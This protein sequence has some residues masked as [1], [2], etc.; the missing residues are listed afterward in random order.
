MLV[1]L[2][3]VV[4][5]LQDRPW[6]PSC[7]IIVFALIT[8]VTSCVGHQGW[9]VPT[10]TDRPVVQKQSGYIRTNDNVQIYYERAG[11]GKNIILIPGSG[12]SI[13][14][15]RRNFDALA[16]QFHVVAVDMRGSGRSQKCDWGHNCA[17][18][19]MD[20][21]ELLH[22]LKMDNVTLVGWSCG[23]RTSYSYLMLFGNHRLHGVVVV[24][25][26]V[27]HT[28][29]N[30]NPEEARQNP[31]ESDEKFI[32]RSMRRMVSP[33]DPDALSTQEVD[34]MV[35]SWT[36]PPA[37]LSADGKAQDWR[38]LCPVIDVPVLI[39]SGR[40]SGALPGCRYAAEHIPDARLEIFEHSGHGLFYSEAEKFNQ[41]VADFVDGSLNSPDNGQREHGGK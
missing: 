19:A 36:R 20:I 11:S 37:A 8:G 4:D 21:Y 27:H 29:Q 9:A 13:G 35:E 34:W 26:T 3:I 30:P 6:H 15:W 18:Y 14:W 10:G 1:A 32:R 16:E 40:H 7:G 12:C 28:I 25:D 22:A 38:P 33:T 39:A 23:A 2:S 17:R 31:G 41:L 5:G 24:D